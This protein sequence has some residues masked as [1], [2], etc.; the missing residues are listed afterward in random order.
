M[1]TIV[2][3]GGNSFIARHLIKRIDKA[4]YRVVAIVRQTVKEPEENV[5]YV[6][7]PMEQYDQLPNM[8]DSCD[9]FLAFAWSGSKKEELDDEQ[10]NEFSYRMLLKCVEGMIEIHKCQKIVLMGS[11]YEYK[12]EGKPISEDT[13]NDPSLAYGKYKLKLY[14]K[15]SELCK[16]EG[17][18]CIEL[19]L[20]SVYGEDDAKDKMFNSVLHKMFHNEPIVMT[21]CKQMYSFIYVDDVVGLILKVINDKRTECDYYN[22]SSETH[23]P[24]REFIEKMKRITKSTSNIDYGGIRYK[25][26][27]VPHIVFLSL[28][29]RKRYGWRERVSFE[30]GVQRAIDCMHDLS[31]S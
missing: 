11:Y 8:M 23:K 9:L 31:R 10:K 26:G 13:G 1:R 2:V 17:V 12:N 27:V 24:L 16:M 3:A 19:R 29:A 22:V 18:S 21:E 20:F 28:K 15:V 14:Q 4:T 25:D 6:I 30:K 5:V 7:L